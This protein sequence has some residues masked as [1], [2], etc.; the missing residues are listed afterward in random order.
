MFGVVTS[1]LGSMYPNC[2][3]FG[4]KV[5][6]YGPL[7]GQSIQSMWA[8]GPIRALLTYPL[9]QGSGLSVCNLGGWRLAREVEE[10]RRGSKRA[11]RNRV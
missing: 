1:P 3:H 2:I 10:E 9:W 8:Q 6:I 11:H 5:P 4:P 7:Q